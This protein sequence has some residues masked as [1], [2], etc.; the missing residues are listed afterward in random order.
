MAPPIWSLRVGGPLERLTYR[1]A[2]V[3]PKME[4]DWKRY[5]VGL[6]VFNTVGA[7]WCTHC[8]GS[9]CGCR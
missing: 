7:R 2:G 5:A 9:R 8:S 6:L 1:V 4:M 3:D